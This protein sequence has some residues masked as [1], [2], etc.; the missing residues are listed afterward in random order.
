[1]EKELTP[2]QIVDSRRQFDV[3]LQTIHESI[4]PADVR[5]LDRVVGRIKRRGVDASSTL[6]LPKIRAV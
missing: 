5:Q 2:Q 1:M 4:V 6:Y 3:E